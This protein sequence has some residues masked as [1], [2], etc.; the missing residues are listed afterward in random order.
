MNIDVDCGIVSND[1]DHLPVALASLSLQ[2]VLP[3]RLHVL[4]DASEKEQETTPILEKLLFRLG[5]CG[6]TCNICIERDL[7]GIP[8]LRGRV[9]TACRGPYIWWID[10][11]VVVEPDCL[12]KLNL[13]A[14]LNPEASFIQGSKL[15]IDATEGY[16]MLRHNSV[17]DVRGTPFVT[18]P[19]G[20]DVP[21][22]IA[23]TANVLFSTEILSRTGGFSRLADAGYRERGSDWVVGALCANV[24]Q[25]FL[26]PAAR[27][28]HLG[29]VNSAG[30]RFESTRYSV[31]SYLDGSVSPE[32]LE[33]VRLTRY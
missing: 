21:I 22:Y 6:V 17:D 19:T 23:D 26:N 11:D 14:E 25:A 9:E 32:V 20:D 28:H 1:M 18:Y 13:S 16:N 27:V 5:N 4:I 33:H 8:A 24:C 12:A 7:H 30:K 29:K 3:S 31:L 15:S 2:S 10:D